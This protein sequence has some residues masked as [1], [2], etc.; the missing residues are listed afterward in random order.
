MYVILKISLSLLTM[1]VCKYVELL[2]GINLLLWNACFFLLLQSVLASWVH[3]ASRE[4]KCFLGG[5]PQT[6]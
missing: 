5:S 1:C 3:I 4:A 6:I 2:I